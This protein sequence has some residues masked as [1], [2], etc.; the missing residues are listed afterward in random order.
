MTPHRI[1]VI[2]V[3]FCIG[4]LHAVIFGFLQY[5]GN[6]FTRNISSFIEKALLFILYF[7]AIFTACAGQVISKNCGLKKTLILGLYA[8]FWG[9]FIFF[10]THF[11]VKT[12]FLFEI[13]LILAMI[14]LGFAFSS[15]FIAIT[16]YIILE[17]LEH[18]II[19]ITILF[20]FMNLGAML[21]PIL[22]NIFN[23][24]DIGWVFGL[25]LCVLILLS[26]RFIN[27]Y[28]FD[29]KFPSHLTHLRKSS[30]LWKKMHYRLGLFILAIICYGICENTFNLFGEQYLLFYVSKSYAFKAASIFWLFLIIGQMIVLIATYFTTIKKIFLLLVVLIIISF[31]LLPYQKSFIRGSFVLALAGIGCSACFPIMLSSL[32]DELKN[33]FKSENYSKLLPY[34]EIS[35]ALMITGYIVG[36][37]FITISLEFLSK[38]TLDTVIFKLHN[39]IV[40]CLVFYLITIFLMDLRKK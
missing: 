1:F 4:C 26:I 5:P 23:S 24:W 31:I 9:V 10:F 2:T 35:T 30:I 32:E 18:V 29:P 25:M 38:I 20:A 14:L 40:Y 21:S 19:G 37:G 34:L 17:F 27:K 11:L 7:S 22:V 3:L 28:F 39:G 36:T 6:F 8:Y 16:T 12:T 13:L 15:V 33:V